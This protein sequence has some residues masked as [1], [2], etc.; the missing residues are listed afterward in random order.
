M[1][2]S[3]GN[4]D[5]I[6]KKNVAVFS[7]HISGGTVSVA[8]SI[9]TMSYSNSIIPCVLENQDSWCERKKMQI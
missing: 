9:E 6:G 5:S 1:L 2:L 3:G 4:G 7:K 8:N